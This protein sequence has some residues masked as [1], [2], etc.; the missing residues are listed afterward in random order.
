[1]KIDFTS[2]E[3]FLINLWAIENKGLIEQTESFANS[4]IISRL[5]KDTTKSILAKTQERKES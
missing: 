4:R 1:M 3:L 5:T 2:D